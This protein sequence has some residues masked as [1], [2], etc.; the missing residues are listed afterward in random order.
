MYISL[1]TMYLFLAELEKEDKLLVQMMQSRTASMEKLNT[2]R[3][4]FIVVASLID[5][6]PNLAG[7]ARTC[8]VGQ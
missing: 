2:G 3:Q 5:R 1:L 4:E 8:E 6:I 7:L